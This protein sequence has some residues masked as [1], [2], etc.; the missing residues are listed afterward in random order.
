MRAHEKWVLN[1]SKMD[2]GFFLHQLTPG[3]LG[4]PVDVLLAR[5]N[6]YLDCSNTPYTLNTCSQDC[7][8]SMHVPQDR[9]LQQKQPHIIGDG[10]KLTPN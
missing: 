4:V 8:G 1:M 7:I 2:Q 10:T 5:F 9:M 3:H 6:S